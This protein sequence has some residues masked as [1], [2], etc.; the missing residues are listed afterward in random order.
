M[1]RLMYYE[2]QI[3]LDDRI[4]SFDSLEIKSEDVGNR[5]VQGTR[6]G[7]LRDTGFG[8]HVIPN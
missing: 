7:G 8:M 3:E 2:M 5:A 4:L 1:Y 6:Y